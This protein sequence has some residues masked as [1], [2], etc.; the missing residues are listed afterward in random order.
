MILLMMLRLLDGRRRISCVHFQVNSGFAQC[1]PRLPPK[2][3]CLGFRPRLCLRL[4]LHLF[5]ALAS[6]MEEQSWKMQVMFVSL[7]DLLGTANFPQGCH[8]KQVILWEFF[9]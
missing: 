7:V 9:P 6:C 8:E 1:R 5:W 3:N 4:A 2:F